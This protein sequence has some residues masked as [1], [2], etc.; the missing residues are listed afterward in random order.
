MI[1]LAGKCV[2]APTNFRLTPSQEDCLFYAG[3]NNSII[4]YLGIK[5]TPDHRRQFLF[6]VL[7]LS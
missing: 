4:S 7:S 3:E 2:N 6:L 5:L 1:H